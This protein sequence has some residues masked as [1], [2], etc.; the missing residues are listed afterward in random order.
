MY[1]LGDGFGSKHS[2]CTVEALSN[3]WNQFPVLLA[4]QYVGSGAVIFH[5]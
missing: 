4:E 1:A 5:T 2:R 3:D